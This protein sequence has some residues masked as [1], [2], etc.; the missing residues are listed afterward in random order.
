MVQKESEAVFKKKKK[1]VPPAT[2]F[3]ASTTATGTAATMNAFKKTIQVKF[4]RKSS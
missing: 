4:P 1:P 3:T 2:A